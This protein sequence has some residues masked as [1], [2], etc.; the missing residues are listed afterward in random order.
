[1]RIGTAEIYR[2][3]ERIDA[4][5]D[6]LIVCIET[7]GGGFFMP[8]FLKLAP[9]A[10]LDAGLQRTIAE[11]LRREC[12]PRHVPDEMYAVPDIPYTLSAKKME[13]PVRRILTG[14][15]P[16]AVAA[17]DAMRNPAAIDFFVDFR[18]VHASRIGAAA[19]LR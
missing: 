12:S 15:E 13:V 7:P 16:A 17:P 19:A 11:R 10:V 5:A 4:V 18:A 14:A 6:S 1:V 9:G 2:C 3:I 8:L